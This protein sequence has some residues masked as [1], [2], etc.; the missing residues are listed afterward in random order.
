LVVL[1]TVFILLS[2]R[3]L[4]GQCVNKAFNSPFGCTDFAVSKDKSILVTLASYDKNS[5]TQVKWFNYSELS[6]TVSV[7]DSAY[8]DGVDLEA[9]MAISDNNKYIVLNGGYKKDFVTLVDMETREVHVINT[10]P[11]EGTYSPVFFRQDNKLKVAV[12]GGYANGKIEIIDVET[13]SLVKSVPAFNHYVYSLAVDSSGQY[14]ACGGFDGELRIYDIGDLAFDTV[15]IVNTGIINKMLFSPDNKYLLIGQGY[16]A[17]KA[18]L[19]IFEIVHST[20]ST[21]TEQP[22]TDDLLIYP[23]PMHDRLFIENA[24]GITHFSLYSV[25]GELIKTG[26]VT[27]NELDFAGLPPATYLIKFFNKD[28]EISSGKIITQ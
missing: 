10:S 1:K 3:K 9:D 16:S 22:E 5:N 15:L 27:G 26:P 14:L 24:K 4:L 2:L 6:D 28:R 23:V 8:I 18:R 13:M 7:I 17:D 11:N 25:Q 19:D 12:G 20:T 21:N